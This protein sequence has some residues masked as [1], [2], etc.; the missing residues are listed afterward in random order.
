MES[1][2]VGVGIRAG[3]GIEFVITENIGLFSLVSHDFVPLYKSS[4][5]NE[6]K[7]ANLHALHLH[8]GARFSILKS[9][10]L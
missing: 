9:K 4:F 2:Q 5:L 8:L 3:V 7:H 10:K 1:N 6:E